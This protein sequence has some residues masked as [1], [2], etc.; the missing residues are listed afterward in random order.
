MGSTGLVGSNVLKQCVAH[1]QISTVHSLARRSSGLAQ[2]N[3]KLNEII[4]KDF[5]NY[6]NIDFTQIDVI[7]YCL[8]ISQNAVSRAEYLDITVNYLDSLFQAIDKDQ[9]SKITFCYCS[10]QGATQA[11]NSLF[12]FAN[13]KGKAEK[14]VIAKKF[15]KSAIFRPGFISPGPGEKTSTLINMYQYL[16]KMFPSMGVTASALAKV[17]INEGLNTTQQYQLLENAD[18]LKKL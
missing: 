13:A 11:E 16:F 8:G 10:G 3:P 2:A 5:K 9:A 1:P 6:R 12:L 17:I 15:E 18:I 4:H 7:Y 14:M